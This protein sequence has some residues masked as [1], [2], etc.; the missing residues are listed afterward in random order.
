MLL[1]YITE[2]LN[3]V[4]VNIKKSYVQAYHFLFSEQ[5]QSKLYVNYI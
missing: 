3:D 4:V 2:Y 1:Q 5:K